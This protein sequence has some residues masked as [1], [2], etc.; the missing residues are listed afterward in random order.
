LATL[1]LAILKTQP[2]LSS[3]DWKD[4]A[5]VHMETTLHLCSLCEQSRRLLVLT[6]CSAIAER[7]RCK[8]RYS[9]RQK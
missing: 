6:R 8:V 2:F 3:R 9:F 4:P 1:F 7:L 5:Y